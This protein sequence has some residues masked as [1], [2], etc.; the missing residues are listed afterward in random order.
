MTDLKPCPFCGCPLI[1]KH[2]RYRAIGNKIVDY[3][4]WEHPFNGCVLDDGVPEG[5]TIYAE[6]IEAWNRRNV[7]SDEIDFDYSAED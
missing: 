3:D 4:A 6:H 5:F 2:I 7:D 1:K